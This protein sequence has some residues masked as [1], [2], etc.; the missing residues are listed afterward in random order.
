[1]AWLSSAP[2]H[3]AAGTFHGVQ[4]QSD[5][6]KT[7]IGTAAGAI[8]GGITYRRVARKSEQGQVPT[9]DTSSAGSPAIMHS[10]QTGRGLRGSL[11]HS[12]VSSACSRASY[13]IGPSSMWQPIHTLTCMGQPANT[14]HV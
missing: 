13:S 7:F 6:W 2:L 14:P 11:L 1:M 4:N 5:N 9:L 3:R 12:H 10:V 8:A